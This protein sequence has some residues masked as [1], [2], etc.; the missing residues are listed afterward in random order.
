MGVGCSSC[1]RSAAA[2]VAF[3]AAQL[4]AAPA[5]DPCR[6]Q[7]LLQ[8]CCGCRAGRCQPRLQLPLQLG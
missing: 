8:L 1:G 4:P 5:A 6:L 3:A 2:A 7:L